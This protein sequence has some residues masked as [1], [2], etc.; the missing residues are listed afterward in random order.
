MQRTIFLVMFSDENGDRVIGQPQATL[1]QAYQ[2]VRTHHAEHVPDRTLAP[3]D[4]EV[5]NTGDV[6][7]DS[8]RLELDGE[9]GMEA[10]TIQRLRVPAAEVDCHVQDIKWDTSGEDEDEPMPELPQQVVLQL[11]AAEV[12]DADEDAMSD[13]ISEALSARYDFAV[14]AFTYVISET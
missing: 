5:P 12:A 1:Q 13:L 14:L 3:L 9:D 7:E 10:Y 4:E 8:V 2:Q 6:E 11:D